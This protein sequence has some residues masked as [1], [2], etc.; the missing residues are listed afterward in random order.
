MTRLRYD[1]D[2]TREIASALVFDRVAGRLEVIMIGKQ[3]AIRAFRTYRVGEHPIPQRIRR[4]RCRLVE[5]ELRDPL[6]AAYADQQTRNRFVKGM[7]ALGIEEGERP[8]SGET[9]EEG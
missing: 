2:F 8:P 3:E 4:L 6:N 7:A 9:T 5:Q 1:G